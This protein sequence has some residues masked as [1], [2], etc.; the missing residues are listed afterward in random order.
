VAPY[1][2]QKSGRVSCDQ[3]ENTQGLVMPK[4]LKK[5]SEKNSQISLENIIA[6]L[7]GNIY[8]LDKN[9]KFLG[10]NNNMLRAIGLNS[11]TEY[12]GKTY[13]DL[14]EKEHIQ[15]IKKT[16]KKVMDNDMAIVLE[17]IAITPGKKPTIY[18][19]RKEP[20]HD[21][22]G[23][24]IGLLGVSTDITKQKRTQEKLLQTKHKLEAM[25][26]ISFSIAHEL[27]TPLATLDLAT[28]SIKKLLPPLLS[29]YE[30]SDKAGISLPEIG[31]DK[32]T[33]LKS[34][35][36][37][38]QD[39]IRASFNFIDMLLMKIKSSV[40]AKSD[41][42]FSLSQCIKDALNHYPLM[43][44]ERDLIDVEISQEFFVKGNALLVRHVFFNLLKNALYYIQSAGKGRISIKTQEDIRF[45]LVYFTD[46]GKGIPAKILPNIFKRF[47]SKT[48]HGAGVGLTFCKMVMESIGGKITCQSVENEYTQFTLKFPK[49]KNKK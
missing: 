6:L 37:D 44:G 1:P 35:L 45:N 47:Y 27:R 15:V 4:L 21:S 41:E 22:S 34:V 30:I 29:S 13:E 49:I 19:T 31:K 39:E 12:I 48:Y 32:I 43:E 5:S 17:E 18:L 3:L 2:I 33:S 14:Y 23:K 20:L 46:T 38:M 8:W 40:S 36:S 9:G 42:I 11:T 24:V 26:A 10:C 7:P 16:D 25:E 28:S